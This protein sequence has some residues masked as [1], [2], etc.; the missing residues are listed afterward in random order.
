[1]VDVDDVEVS[2]DG[3]AEIQICQMFEATWHSKRYEQDSMK[4]R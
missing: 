4:G 2:N 1:M 3:L